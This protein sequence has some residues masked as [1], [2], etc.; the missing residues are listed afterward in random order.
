[1]VPSSMR[2]EVNGI[3][4][5]RMPE[6]GQSPQTAVQKAAWSAE[7]VVGLAGHGLAIPNQAPTTAGVAAVFFARTFLGVLTANSS[8]AIASKAKTVNSDLRNFME[9]SSPA[10]SPF[11]KLVWMV[12]T[13]MP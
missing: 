3:S 9:S 11:L 7:S 4:G 10:R 2:V 12:S 1:M 13:G 6:L 8:T 5:G